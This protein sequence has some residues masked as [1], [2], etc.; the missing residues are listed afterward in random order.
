MQIIGALLLGW[1]QCGSER[2]PM[3]AQDGHSVA[4]LLYLVLYRLCALLCSKLLV[5]P[6][7]RRHARWRIRGAARVKPALRFPGCPVF[8]DFGKPPEPYATHSPVSQVI[9][10][11]AFSVSVRSRRRGSG[12]FR[13]VPPFAAMA[14]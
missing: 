11:G 8:R 10:P 6:L 2:V 4:G 1:H 14:C 5:L 12:K 9:T 3:T 13:V 7:G